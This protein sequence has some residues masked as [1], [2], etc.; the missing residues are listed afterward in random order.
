MVSVPIY[1][2]NK[3]NILNILLEKYLIK[4]QVYIYAW[5]YLMGTLEN[6]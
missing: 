6:K 4:G 2:P 1:P 5:Q 3:Q